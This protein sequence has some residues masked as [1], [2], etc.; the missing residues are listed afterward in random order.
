MERNDPAT[1]ITRS[2]VYTMWQKIKYGKYVRNIFGGVGTRNYIIR[3]VAVS[4]EHVLV[5]IHAK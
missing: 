1:S 4:Q 5:C 2:R 3:V